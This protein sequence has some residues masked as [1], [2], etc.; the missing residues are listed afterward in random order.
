MKLEPGC[1]ALLVGKNLHPENRNRIVLVEKCLG[2]LP[3]GHVIVIGG[4]R[5][6]SESA[7]EYW[8]CSSGDKPLFSA[9]GKFAANIRPIEK[10]CLIPISGPSINT[11][12][13][14]EEDKPV[15]VT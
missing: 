13:T 11:D 14:T 12:E 5:W 9:N 4:K 15:E 6:R 7:E 3:L 2:V 8:V 1:M 10:R